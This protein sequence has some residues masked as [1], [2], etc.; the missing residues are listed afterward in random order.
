MNKNGMEM[1][2]DVFGKQQLIEYRVGNL[3]DWNEVRTGRYDQIVKALN[4][5][6]GILFCRQWG[7]VPRL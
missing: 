3:S 6:L 5:K 4:A 7:V 2:E 1:C